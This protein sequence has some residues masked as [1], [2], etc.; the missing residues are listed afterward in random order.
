MMK[1][2]MKI[3]VVMK[4]L[5]NKLVVVVSNKLLLLVLKEDLLED[6]LKD[7]MKDFLDIMKVLLL[8]N[9]EKLLKLRMV[10]GILKKSPITLSNLLSL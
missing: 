10:Y 7:L 6:L 1:L 2:H 8:L 9:S 3:M 4:L 5:L